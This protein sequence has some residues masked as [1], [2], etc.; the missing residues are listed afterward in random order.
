MLGTDRKSTRS[1]NLENWLWKRLWTCRKTDYESQ[2]TIV[3]Q[4]NFETLHA[5][6]QYLT[7]AENLHAFHVGF[8]H[9]ILFDLHY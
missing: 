2:S 7:N 4:F 5:I 9:S 3:A 6:H 8:Q 1:H